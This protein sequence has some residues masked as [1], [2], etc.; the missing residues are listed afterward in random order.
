MNSITEQLIQQQVGTNHI[1]QMLVEDTN[2]ENVGCSVL[3]V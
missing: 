1:L 2:E 3:E